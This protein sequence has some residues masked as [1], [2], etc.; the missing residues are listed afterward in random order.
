MS[1]SK[2]CEVKAPFVSIFPGFSAGDGAN[3]MSSRI[4]RS[5]SSSLF[6][7]FFLPV[8]LPVLLFLPFLVVMH[9]SL[10]IPTAALSLACVVLPH[11]EPQPALIIVGSASRFFDADGRMFAKLHQAGL[12]KAHD[13]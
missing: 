6:S 8:L 9:S 13:A 7:D 11:R 10:G 1:Q 4:W 2:V 3:V 12:V 5:D